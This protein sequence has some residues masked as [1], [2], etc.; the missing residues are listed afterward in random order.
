MS[1]NWYLKVK[2]ATN[3]RTCRRRNTTTSTIL[4]G[5]EIICSSSSLHP[6][7]L[8]LALVLL[9]TA[10]QV[11]P[12]LKQHALANELEPRGELVRLVLEH[13]L[14]LIRRDVLRVAHLVRVDVQVD[15]GLDEQDVINLVLAPLAVTGRLV[16]YSCEEVELLDWHLLGL[17]TKLLVKLALRRALDALNGKRQGG[18]SLGGN[19]QRV[20]AAGVGPEVGE[21][22]L[23][24]GSLLEQQ[25]ILGVEEEDGECAVKEAFV[26]VLH[27]VAH[28][29]AGTADRH[30]ILV[31]NDADLVH[32]PDLLF[33][34]SRKVIVLGR[35]VLCLRSELGVDL[36]EEAK[37]VARV[38]RLGLRYGGGGAHVDWNDC[39]AFCCSVSEER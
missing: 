9:E 19:A 18:A 12:P 23:L 36:G 24:G 4:P 17:D 14:Q 3:A 15:I 8:R 26:D 21:R 2:S 6:P 29:L 5:S 16:V 39:V 27:K 13:C 33:I 22:D 35:R 20:G 34:I 1:H 10:V 28:L 38:I 11:V 30:I 31:Q 25:A 32:Q 37:D 7:D